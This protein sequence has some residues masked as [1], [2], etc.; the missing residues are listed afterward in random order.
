MPAWQRVLSLEAGLANLADG[1]IERLTALAAA[2]SQP[3]PVGDDPRL[4]LVDKPLP[5]HLELVGG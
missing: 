3:L 2:D 1:Q 4:V 5:Y